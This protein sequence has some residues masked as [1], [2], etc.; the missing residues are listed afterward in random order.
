MLFRSEVVEALGNINA[1]AALASGS[2]GQAL[3]E[4]LL[5]SGELVELAQNAVKPFYDGKRREVISFINE[6]F[7]GTEYHYHAIEGSIFCFLYLPSLKIPT[8]EFYS[9]LKEKGVITVPG[10][11][12]FFGHEDQKKGLKYPHPHYD[13]T[14]R[15]NYSADSET[16]RE[17]IRIMSE[18]YRK[19]S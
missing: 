7:E 5:R 6:F 11:Y 13:R 15:I 3:A 12:F 2:M 8:I 9:R 19:W 1:I 18:L 16:V 4:D 14:L 10:E 17:G